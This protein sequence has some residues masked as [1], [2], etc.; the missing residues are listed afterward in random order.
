MNQKHKIINDW[1]VLT[2][3]GWSDFSG[4]KKVTKRVYYRITFTDNTILECSECHRLK[5]SDNTIRRASQIF[6]GYVLLGKDGINKVVKSKRKIKKKV[7]LYDL[8]D[9]KKDSQY[10]VNDVVGKNCA[11]I[12]GVEEIWISAQS[13]IGQGGKAILLSTP[14]GTGGFFHKTWME[15]EEKRNEFNKI[16]LK[17]DLH[18]ERDQAWRDKQTELLG[19]KGANQECDCSFNTSGNTVI[20]I[21]TLQWFRDNTMQKP[22]EMKG[23]DKSFWVWE[24]PDYSKDYLISADVSRGDGQDY[25]AF[26][27]IDVESL[28]QVAEYRGQVGTK[29]YGNMLV[30]AATEYNT[31]L[32]L[33]ENANVG[34][35]TLQQ[36]IDLEYS[37]IFYTMTDVKYVDENQQISNRFNALEKKKVPG[38]TTSTRTRP[39]IIAKMET[40]FREKSVVVKSERTLN[41]LSVFVWE[42][43]KAQA[44]RGYNDDLAMSLAMG[45]WVRDTAIRMRRQGMELN[46]NL[47]GNVTRVNNN[48]N[49]AVVPIYMPSKTRGMETWRMPTN[50]ANK[51]SIG[52]NTESLTWL[53]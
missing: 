5:L 53:L 41:E 18:P 29:E 51:D 14:S 20:E 38:F 46:K 9:V 19:V 35:A 37:N 15:A 33:V 27:I 48:S 30:A 3:D 6:K 16:K 17:W 42:N 39:L 25:S 22:I 24:Y 52:G 34:W 8:T 12:P 45:L 44:M 7:D 43:G 28:T 13:T 23:F 47:L 10:Y 4:I 1:E 49:N 40:Y 21:E 11:F 36:I 26:H 32:L 31:G 2:P 50:P